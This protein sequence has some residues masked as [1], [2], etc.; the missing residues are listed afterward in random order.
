[1]TSNSNTLLAAG[2]PLPVITFP[3]VGGGTASVG[4]AG[5]QT[6]LFIVYRGKHCPRCKKYLNQLES[7]KKDWADAG[8]SVVCV[9]ADTESKAA[10]D[11]A[12]FGWTFPVGYDLAEADMRKLGLY[13]S[14]PLSPEETDKRFA[15]PGVYVV[16]PDG[17]VQ[18]IAISNGPAARPD[19]VELLDGVNF[20]IKNDRPTRGMVV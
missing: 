18:I 11:V 5:D 6:T 19:L 12:E 8:V 1:M 7:M 17:T 10:A 4:E 14:E 16:K 20:N 15:E 13:V 9:S 3:L 2:Q